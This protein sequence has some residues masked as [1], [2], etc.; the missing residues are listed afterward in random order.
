MAPGNDY[1]GDGSLE[2]GMPMGQIKALLAAGLT[3]IE[4]IEASTKHT[5]RVCGHGD[6]LGTLEPGKLADVVI[7]AWSN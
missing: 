3:P 4:V 5:A 2:Q 1:P 6:E 7:V